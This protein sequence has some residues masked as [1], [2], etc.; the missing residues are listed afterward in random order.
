MERRLQ[1]PEMTSLVP[2]SR[3]LGRV[4][5]KANFKNSLKIWVLTKFKNFCDIS[6]NSIRRFNWAKKIFWGYRHFKEK[7]KKDQPQDAGIV[8]EHKMKMN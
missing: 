2:F 1:W 4:L 3:L 7:E 8:E 5:D 6:P